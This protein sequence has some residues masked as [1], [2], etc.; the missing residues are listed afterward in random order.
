MS[1]ELCSELLVQDTRS[2]NA[3]LRS[4]RESPLCQA[5]WLSR[6]NRS[7]HANRVKIRWST[8]LLQW[9]SSINA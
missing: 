7:I 8:Q 4:T 9:V 3:L 1:Q 2:D 6:S 5:F